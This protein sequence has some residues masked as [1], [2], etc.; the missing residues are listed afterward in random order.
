MLL[1]F[2]ETFVDPRRASKKDRAHEEENRDRGGEEGHDFEDHRCSHC[3]V[4]GILA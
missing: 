2:P 3:R 1:E 4:N